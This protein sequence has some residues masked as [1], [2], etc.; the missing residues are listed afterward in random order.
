M[1][2]KKRALADLKA[3]ATWFLAWYGCIPAR[4]VLTLIVLQFVQAVLLVDEIE[5][6]F[7]EIGKVVGLMDHFGWY[8][9]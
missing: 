5:Q 9:S 4:S 1:S 8:G 6:V 3:L 2:S 7:G